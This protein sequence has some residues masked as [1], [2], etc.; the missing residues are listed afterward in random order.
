MNSFWNGALARFKTLPNLY[1]VFIVTGVFLF[2]GKAGLDVGHALGRF[3]FDVT[4]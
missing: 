2:A 3:L 1:R 4:H